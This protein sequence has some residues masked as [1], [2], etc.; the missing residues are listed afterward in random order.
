M[1]ITSRNVNGIRAVLNKWFCEWILQDNPD[2]LCLQETKAFENQ[3]PAELKY[4]LRDYNYI[5]HTGTRSGYAWTT[6]FYKKNLEIIS[7]KNTFENFPKFDED[8]S[9]VEL[10]F[11]N[12]DTEIML[13]NIY[14]PNGWTRADW[15]EM[16]SYKLD[17]YEDVIKYINSQ[18]DE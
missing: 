2:I 10:T 4:T 1:K 13:L 7:T 12:N 15:T 18:R 11:K 8:G 3:I 14:F 5:R 6:T 9:V 17:F 16:L